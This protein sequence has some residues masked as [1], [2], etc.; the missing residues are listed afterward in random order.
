MAAREDHE[1]AG[2]DSDFYALKR[3]AVLRRLLLPV[4]RDLPPGSSVAEVG[5]GPGGNLAEMAGLGLRHVGVDGS[6]T[7]LAMARERLPRAGLL[8]ADGA[9]LP[10]GDGTVDLCLFVTVLQHNPPAAARAMLAEACRVSR[11]RVVLVEDTCALPLRDR[12]S[13]WLR[14]PGWYAAA[15]VPH[16]YVL[17]ER[18]RLPLGLTE[19]AVGVG[20]LLSGSLREGEAS[21][22][23]RRAVERRLLRHLPRLDAALRLPLGIQRLE[24]VRG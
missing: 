17:R 3:H 9:R 19:A 11:G 2:D 24:L 12:R 6:A 5:C 20:R 8:R 13:H 21:G 15:A 23:A 22:G 1:L 7:M 14:R 4:L 16:G 18:T 10:L